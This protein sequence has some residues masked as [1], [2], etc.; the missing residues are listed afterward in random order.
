MRKIRPGG[1]V[2]IAGHW[3]HP[4]EKSVKYDNRLDGFYAYFAAYMNDEGTDYRDFVAYSITVGYDTPESF[5]RDP[6]WVNGSL[7]W[8]WWYRI[9]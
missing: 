1:R 5:D 6:R 9:D 3:Y 7:P 4:E 8:Q 2:K